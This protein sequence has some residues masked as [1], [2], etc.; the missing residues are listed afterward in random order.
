MIEIDLNRV[1][2]LLSKER[3]LFHNEKDFQFSLAWKFQQLNPELSVRLE[4]S[5]GDNREQSEYL[6]I[7]VSDRKNVEIGIELKYITALLVTKQ[8]DEQ[9]SLK[10]HSANDTRCYDSLK[11]LERIERLVANKYI[12]QGYTIWLTNV[13][14]F[15]NGQPNG[16][17][18]D[19]F[20][21]FESRKINGTLNWKTGAGKGTIKNREKPINIKG[22]YDIKWSKYSDVVPAPIVMPYTKGTFKYCIIEVTS[23]SKD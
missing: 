22:T 16:S 12:S 21:I 9:F 1:M 6:D 17:L 20:R 15:W 23:I 11:D 18:Y 5:F 14:A 10:N 19:E 7:F 4:K 2:S 13:N 3:P 8:K